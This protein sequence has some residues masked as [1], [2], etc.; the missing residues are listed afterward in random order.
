MTTTH[1][2]KTTT[3]TLHLVKGEHAWA[4]Y[5]PGEWWTDP[6][7]DYIDHDEMPGI[8]AHAAAGALG[9]TIVRPLDQH[10]YDWDGGVVDDQAY[11]VETTT[12]EGTMS[13]TNG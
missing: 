6:P 5:Q 2:T 9:V 4:L 7:V 3:T 1:T 8:E 10:E 11:E 13:T 12:R